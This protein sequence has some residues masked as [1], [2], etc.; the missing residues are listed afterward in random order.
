MNFLD[1]KTLIM[2]KFSIL[3]AT[4]ALPF[5][6]VWTTFILTGFNF[7]PHNVFNEGAFWGLSTIYWFLWVCLSPLI[8][9]MIDEHEKLELKNN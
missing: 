9:E 7:N 5:L 1:D 6:L 2:K 8:I 4:A 3:M